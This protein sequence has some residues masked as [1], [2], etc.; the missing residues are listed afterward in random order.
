[1]ALSG[2]WAVAITSASAFVVSLFSLWKIYLAAF[3]LKVSYSSPSF[4]LYRMDPEVSGGQMPWWIP[5]I[6]MTFTFYNTG[7]R[8]GE[9][10]DVRIVGALKT[11]KDAD[12]RK[13]IFYAKWV[14]DYK[15]LQQKRGDRLGLTDSVE[16]DWYPLILS[17]DSQKT[18]HIIL[19][20]WRWDKKP[21][22]VLTLKL[23]IYS[24]DKDA[25]VDYDEYTRIIAEHMYESTSIYT[26]LNKQLEKTRTN[27]T[28]Q[29]ANM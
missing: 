26:L 15:K 2:Q 9:V 29:W 18:V 7:K 16:T 5:S 21:T 4:S 25:W 14:V 23:Q 24:T 1:M 6:D 10:I 28:Q 12:E 8:S 20:G 3:K 19:E 17:G 22:G 13:F 27:L 11:S